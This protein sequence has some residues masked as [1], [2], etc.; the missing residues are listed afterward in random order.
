[1]K[2]N[3][4]GL[5]YIGLPLA[6]FFAKSGMDV[7]GT[8]VNENLIKNLND[9]KTFS[10]EN[11]LSPLL[12]EVI[13]TGKLKV[14]INIKEA[15][16]FI[17]AVP[18]P[19]KENHLPDLSHIEDAV[20]NVAK[21]LKHGNLIVLE[22]TS[23][24]GTTKH[25]QE[26]L[27][28]LRPDLNIEKNIYI[29]Y[30]PERMLP[31]NFSEL[32]ENDRII[33]G[34]NEESAQKAKELYK[35]IIKGDIFITTA[36]TAEMVK[37]AENSFRDVNIAFA[38]ELSMICDKQNINVNDVINL[39]NH[40]PRVNILKPGCGVGGH[41]VAVDPWFVV[42]Q[43]PD[44]A[45]LIKQAREVNDYKP[46]F[47]I[48]KILNAI[49][50]LNIQNPSISCF[51]LAFKPDINDLRESPALFICEKLSEL[52]KNIKVVEPN[53]STLPQ[54]LQENGAELT[55]TDEALKSDI[56]VLLVEHKEFKQIKPQFDKNTQRLID[57]RGIW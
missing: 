47:V 6:V 5:G 10:K 39:A 33:G 29:A 53:I 9:K 55:G 20:K 40:H 36:E 41:C 22:S 38:N 48:D 56:I 17:I 57:T 46:Q 44:E 25:I 49:K 52:Y 34:I 43:N 15:D 31:G 1:M 50:E 3:I 35:K 14:S 32:L 27:K 13:D 21:V 19:F 18:T 51:G 24:V 2:L 37:L 16:T 26:M 4:I 7:F 8:D 12:T 23:P 45:K 42:S 11:E 28:Q 30:A 54:K